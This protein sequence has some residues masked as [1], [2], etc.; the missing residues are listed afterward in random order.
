M[1]APDTSK[2]AEILTANNERAQ[3]LRES[4][5]YLPTCLNNPLDPAEFHVPKDLI[6]HG[7]ALDNSHGTGLYLQRLFPDN[8]AF[9]SLRTF[10]TD[11]DDQ[12]F[13]STQLYIERQ[14]TPDRQSA[15]NA[16]VIALQGQ[17]IRRI[18]C[19]PYHVEDAWN[20]IAAH[21][22]TG[23]PL[24][25]YILDDTH[26][27]ESFIPYKLQSELL[28][29]SRVSFAVSPL[30]CQA[31]QS[32]FGRPV[33]FLPPVAS[34]HSL[35]VSPS[36]IPPESPER[37]VMIG[38][39][40]SASWMR[41]LI[42][43]VA[44]L[45]HTIDWFCPQKNLSFPDLKDDIENAGIR[46]HGAEF[47]HEKDLLAKLEEYH[48]A[49]IPS[50]DLSEKDDRKAISRFSLPSRM[51]NLAATTG[52]PLLVI[53]SQ[54]TSAAAFVNQFQLGT[55]CPYDS[56][57]VAASLGYLLAPSQQ[58]AI[59]ER[60]AKLA[61]LWSDR[62][63]GD[64]IW[65]SLELGRPADNRF[66]LHSTSSPVSETSFNSS[67]Y[68]RLNSRRLEHLAQMEL[69]LEGKSILELGSG[70]GD[71]SPFF[72]DRG[73]NLTLS[74]VRP[75]LINVLTEKFPDQDVLRID[76][77]EEPVGISPFDVVFAYGLLY[78]LTDLES[79]I[80]NL[81]TLSKSYV[82]LSTCVN[83]DDDEDILLSEPISDPTQAY[84]G[85][86]N[87][88]SRR[89]LFELLQKYF[90]N[91]YMPRFLPAHPEYPTSWPV[92]SENETASLARVI[93]IAAHEALDCPSLQ[94]LTLH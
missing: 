62:G 57:K 47:R 91:C 23:A 75:E 73:F 78:H 94:S 22:I 89:L 71:L 24:C 26:L 27:I 87:R 21:Q 46:F 31:L 63:I 65:D 72:I 13:G 86:G 92:L 33:H 6:I 15:F 30:L 37:I 80:K 74:D 28:R 49:I 12:D 50:G 55:C 19:I 3:A 10:R 90:S 76:L 8:N 53:G 29:C 70:Q 39:V 18:L 7:P 20:A 84:H 44:P 38:N 16:M 48:V 82:I 14:T 88:P 35:R 69:P 56:G 9:I 45:P 52:I 17:K 85:R 42:E 68:Q 41:Q 81:A 60:A 51:L 83:P 1:T 36:T 32:K 25:T 43:S 67:A 5:G 66:H 40:W 79:G 61:P 2:L 59:R 34:Q 58:K 4:A 77:E 54:H 11:N 64:W 93:V